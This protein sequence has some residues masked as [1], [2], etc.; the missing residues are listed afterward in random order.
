VTDQANYAFPSDL[1][2]FI[3]TTAWDRAQKWPLMGPVS[4]Q[5]W[6]V[7][8]SGTIGSV[9]PRK[10]FRIM[11][12]EIYF[13]P[14]PPS[15]ENGNTVVIEYYSN[16]WCES[17]SSDPQ[18]IWTSDGD[19]PVLPDDCFIMGIQWRFKAAKGL[20]YQEEFNIYEDTVTRSMARSGMAPVLSLTGSLSGVRFLDHD[21]IPDS[22]YGDS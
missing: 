14:T 4:P 15:G 6:Q 3:N 21:N 11:A 10:R 7:L 5:E 18:S 16:A 12:G 8:K 9:G 13:D 2:Y 1:Q 19:L 20:D 17:A 22:G